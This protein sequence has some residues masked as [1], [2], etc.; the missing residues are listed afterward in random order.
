MPAD[1]NKNYRKHHLRMMREHKGG[2]SSEQYKKFVL[3]TADN[4]GRLYPPPLGD[5]FARYSILM[6]MVIVDKTVDIRSRH[7]EPIR[8]YINRKG[9]AEVSGD[10]D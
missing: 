4:D 9:Q 1:D 8:W 3:S 10:A 2:I 7:D 6:G 5:G